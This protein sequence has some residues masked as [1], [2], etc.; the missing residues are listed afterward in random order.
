MNN[1]LGIFTGVSHTVVNRGY[2]GDTA[3]ACYN[4]WGQI[5][6]DVA[7]IMLGTNDAAGASGATFEEYMQYMELLIQRYITWGMGVVIHT[8]TPQRFGSMNDEASKYTAAAAKMARQYSC[9]VFESDTSVQYAM[10]DGVYSDN[11]HFNAH[12]YNKYGNAVAAFIIAGG[13]VREPKMVKGEIHLQPKRGYEGIGYVETGVTSDFTTGSYLTNRAVVGFNKVGDRLSY[14]FFMDTEFAEIHAVGSLSGLNFELSYQLGAQYSGDVRGAAS[15]NRTTIKSYRAL[16]VAE[17]TN[18]IS[19]GGRTAQKG[20]DTYIGALVGRGWKTVSI[21]AP[22]GFTG[23]SYFNGIIIRE[24]GIDEITATPVLNSLVVKP[25]TPEAYAIQIPYSKDT[26][27]SASAPAAQSLPASVYFPLPKSLYPY[28]GNL[29]Q[30]YDNLPVELLI[31]MSTGWQKVLAYKVNGS[32][33]T[34]LSV[35]AVSGNLASLIPT[36]MTIV[37]KAFSESA[38]GPDGDFVAGFGSETSSLYLKVNFGST[39]S[40]YYSL[41]L[42]SYGKSGV[43]TMGR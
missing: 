35:Q 17:N 36:S 11:V 5:A 20:K 6:G 22:T 28:T 26:D 12:G 21:S 34:T 13:W 4:R 3:K 43:A 10:Y 30:W 29:T 33:G 27:S 32:D 38:G 25:V 24:K 23:T 18:Y 15:V 14:T 7:H 39:P 41:L 8:A 2:S 31:T 1:I 37:S 40:S 42:T 19:P 9:P 16:S